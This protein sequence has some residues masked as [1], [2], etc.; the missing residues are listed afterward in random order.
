MANFNPLDI[1][2]VAITIEKFNKTDKMSLLPQF[3][4][5]SVY[6][7]IFE[8]SIKAEML[9]NDQIGLFV[10]YPFT[11][12]ELIT[13]SYEYNTNLAS[14][15]GPAKT[16]K[17]YKFIIKGVRNIV[18][19]D[20]ARSLMYVVE[21]ISPY[22]LQNVRKYVSHGYNEKVE[23]AA[24]K[25]FDEY[26][27]EDTKALYNIGKPFVKETSSKVRTLIVPNLRP[28]QGIKWLAKHAVSADPDNHFTYLFYED[29]EKFNFITIQKLIEE[30]LKKRESLRQ[31]KYVYISDIELNN[32]SPTGDPDQDLRIITNLINN[33]R[34]SSIEKIASGYYQNELFEISMLQKAYNSKVTE[35]T[36]TKDKPFTLEKYPLNTQKYIDYVKNENAKSEYT[37]RIRYIVN[38]YDNFNDDI[39]KTQ[40][41]YRLKFGNTVKYNHALNQIDL[42]ATVPANINLKAGDI[43]YC[44]IPEMHGFN[45]VLTDIYI[46]GMFIISEI[47]TVF[48]AGDKAATSIRIYKDGYLNQ[49]L[50]ESEYN[51]SI[52]SPVVKYGHA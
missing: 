2:I 28:F 42:S 13:I 19:G 22:Y 36:G 17:E 12:E 25:L 21:L 26:L 49:L 52:S 11:G 48:S 4:E 27:A 31:K 38:N 50:E 24:E 14:A 39:G 23:D 34:F 20:K 8:S 3:V 47:K 9:I 51:S 44:D 6:Q 37:N 33:K 46:S 35:H 45:N 5:V 29:T 43:I 15:I 10:N 16:V 7:S 32:A 41:G 18:L 40:P 1:K 30:A